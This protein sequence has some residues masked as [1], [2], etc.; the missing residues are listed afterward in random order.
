MKEND[1]IRNERGKWI[2]CIR[3]RSRPPFAKTRA[4]SGGAKLKS[5]R[6][7]L[8]YTFVGYV[9]SADCGFRVAHSLKTVCTACAL[10]YIIIFITTIIIIITIITIIR[11]TLYVKV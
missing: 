10:L 9:A 3:T 2:G 8:E 1:A 11:V 7:E 5:L 6:S 4:L